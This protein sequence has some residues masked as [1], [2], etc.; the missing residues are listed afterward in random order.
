MS[1]L[2]DDCTNHSLPE[3]SSKPHG[4]NTQLLP[5]CFAGFLPHPLVLFLS[6]LGR[7]TASL[8]VD[9][10]QQFP[11]RPHGVLELFQLGLHLCLR[12]QWLR[13]HSHTSAR[14]LRPRCTLP[15]KPWVLV[16]TLCIRYYKAGCTTDT[17]VAACSVRFPRKCGSPVPVNSITWRPAAEAGKERAQ[18]KA[19]ILRLVARPPA[20]PTC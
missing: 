6:P 5:E 9:R 18:K 20:T 17:Q 4:Y 11:L 3:I 10:S 13:P 14:R 15:C 8:V 7:L 19:M 16:Y 12:S 1:E 2:V